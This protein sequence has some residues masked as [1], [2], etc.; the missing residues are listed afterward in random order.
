MKIRSVLT[1]AAASVAL[2]L[3]GCS[4]TVEGAGAPQAGQA[5]AESPATSATEGPDE[6]TESA[7]GSSEESAQEST[8]ESSEESTES[9]DATEESTEADAGG[10]A[11]SPTVED[12]AALMAEGSA[13]VDS[14]RGTVV[15][16]SSVGGLQGTYEL[17]GINSG[18][19]SLLMKMSQEAAGQTVDLSILSVDGVAYLGGDTILTA[20]GVAAPA[21]KWIALDENSSNPL[22]AQMA[23]QMETATAQAG[24]AQAVQLAKVAK[25]VTEVGPT[26]AEGYDV[27]E[28]ELVV[29]GSSVGSTGDVPVRLWLTPEGALVKL[30]MDQTVGG[31]AATMT[32]TQT[33][34]NEPVDIT[35][36]TP[37]QLAVVPG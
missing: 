28:Y 11:G 23:G 15:Q 2:V 20:L 16:D 27:V 21:G 6:S 17:S 4:G 22:L 3:T 9:S 14:A 7:E 12:F 1:A 34:H 5:S 19:P 30:V 31:V 33:H 37:E 24:S 29:V 25:S 26:E 32:M 36:P 10:S 13:G 35:A 18:T 8:D